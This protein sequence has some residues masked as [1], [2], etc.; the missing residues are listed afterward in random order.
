MSDVYAVGAGG[1]I[2]H[3]D[4]SSWSKQTTPTT[5]SLTRVWGMGPTRVYA[6][7]D[8]S[9]LLRYDG[10][11]WRAVLFPP[12]TLSAI[13]VNTETDAVQRSTATGAVV[14]QW[15]GSTWTTVLSGI[16]FPT[17]PWMGTDGSALVGQNTSVG[18]G[19][20]WDGVVWQG[21]KLIRNTAQFMG[22]SIDNFWGL[23]TQTGSCCTWSHYTSPLSGNTDA[24]YRTDAQDTGFPRITRPLWYYDGTAW[25]V[26]YTTGHVFRGKQDEGILAGNA[27]WGQ[28]RSDVFMVGDGGSIVRRRP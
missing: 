12:R 5:A 9:V 10:V 28:S 27:M 21:A 24:R 11:S 15:D 26:E 19:Y 2:L 14:Q 4:G 25:V 6:T 20:Y 7:D 18:Q 13:W 23:N 3:F 22:K 1:T 17:G 8:A 16:D